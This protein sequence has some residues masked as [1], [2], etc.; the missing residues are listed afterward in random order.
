MTLV[1]VKELFL[2]EYRVHRYLK[3]LD[4]NLLKILIR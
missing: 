2:S 4:K 1:V 3:Y